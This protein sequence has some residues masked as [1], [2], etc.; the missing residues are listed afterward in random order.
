MRC[1]KGITIQGIS[2]MVDILSKVSTEMMRQVQEE[3]LEISKVMC[4]VKLGRK[5]SL[6]QI[7]K[8]KSK[9]A[10]RYLQQFDQLVFINRVL[11]RVY[12]QNG[13]K[14]HQLVLPFEYRALAIGMLHD[15]NGHQGVEHTIALA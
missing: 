15:D 3:D 14:Y 12:E 5:P 11:H 2:T 9:I 13:S 4:Y 10:C 7:R 6:S 8:L 1:Q